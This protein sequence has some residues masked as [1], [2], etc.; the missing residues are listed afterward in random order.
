MSDMSHLSDAAPYFG[1]AIVAHMAS[2]ALLPQTMADAYSLLGCF[3]A[4]PM[5]FDNLI[6]KESE[7]LLRQVNGH[8][9]GEL[10][11]VC[12]GLG[13]KCLSLGLV[14]IGLYKMP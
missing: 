2:K 11:N 6:Q 13:C 9:A 4:W 12:L 7:H 10:V 14:A 1:G 5:T 8:I 3:F